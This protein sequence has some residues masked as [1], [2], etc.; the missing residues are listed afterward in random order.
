MSFE[1]FKSKDLTINLVLPD[2]KFL[3]WVEDRRLQA[4]HL[5]G[6]SISWAQEYEMLE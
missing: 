4:I 6:L 3:S 2:D 1:N 5:K